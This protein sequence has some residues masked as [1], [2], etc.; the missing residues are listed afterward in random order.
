[1]KLL[2]P[3]FLVVLS[4]VILGCSGNEEHGV[5]EVLGRHISAA[6]FTERYHQYL[7][8]FSQRDNI[9]LR[10]QVLNNMI[11]ERLIFDDIARCGLDT[12]P[13]ALKRLREIRLQ[14]LLDAYARRISVD[15]MSVSDLDFQR[16]FRNFNTSVTAR[17]V[18]AKS[19]QGALALRNR[20]EQGESFESVARDV[21]DDPGL[22]ANGGYLGSF[23]WGEMEPA[24]EQAAFS[25]PVGTLSEPVRLSMGYAIV[26]VESRFRSPLASEYDYARNKPQLEREIRA[27]KALQYVSDAVTRA[28]ETLSTEVNREALLDLYAYWEMVHPEGGTPD[29]EGTPLQVIQKPHRELVTFRG[30]SW[31]ISDFL[32]ELEFTSTRQRRRVKSV[33]DLE[34]V[35]IGLVARQELLREAENLDLEET[36]DVKAQVRRVSDEYLLK[37]WA[38]HVQDTVGQNGW[39]ELMLRKEYAS[40]KGEFAFPPEVNVAE[41]LVRTNPEANAVLQELKRGK[42]FGQL[43]RER[44]IRR[45]AAKRGGELGYG[46]SSHFGI[47]GEKFLA[48]GV[49]DL[50]GPE[51]VDPY[52]GVFKILGRKEARPMSFDQAKPSIIAGLARVRKLQVFREAV[53]A[54]RT[55][56]GFR[57]DMDVLS[58]LH[59]LPIAAKEK[60]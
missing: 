45:W 42:D 51:F 9:L 50:L 1:M 33:D 10:E 34:T 4:L 15:T 28:T 53:E 49:G 41:I 19:R 46:N 26:K 22:A 8:Q 25:Q 31:T 12:D 60:L 18:Y 40:R 58:T 35:V 56:I 43:A 7:A 5:A 37:R 16:E 59:V 55:R 47:L 21:F 36:P 38:R 27:R 32:D 29:P 23:G 3:H 57:I 14:A 17:Y 44:S 48:A 11:N 54:L 52:F 20:L 30:G 39:D 13:E 24:L 2:K 6:E